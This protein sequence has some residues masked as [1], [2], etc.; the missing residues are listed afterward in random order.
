MY[1]AYSTNEKR[2]TYGLLMGNL[3]GKRPLGRPRPRRVNNIKIDPGEVVWVN[4]ALDRGQWR[5]LV[6]AVMNHVF[7]KMLRSS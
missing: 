7:H 4:L 5:T 1:M 3:E 2:R 6:N